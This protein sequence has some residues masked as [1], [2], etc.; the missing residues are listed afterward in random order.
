MLHGEA[1]GKSAPTD[2]KLLLF[3]WGTPQKQGKGGGATPWL[4]ILALVPKPR[5]Q[6]ALKEKSQQFLEQTVP[7]LVSDTVFKRV[8]VSV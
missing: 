6:T 2:G 1:F 8:L 7:F 4:A 3:S 5:G